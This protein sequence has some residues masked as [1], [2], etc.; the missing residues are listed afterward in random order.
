M[1]GLPCQEMR[2]EVEPSELLRLLSSASVDTALWL[3]HQASRRKARRKYLELARR[4]HP[5]KWSLQGELCIAIATDVTKCLV[6]A[7]EQAMRDLPQDNDR[8][9]CED[10]DED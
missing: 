9:T 1:G 4:W 2:W 10:D 6:H 3:G 8:V 5:D 7:Y